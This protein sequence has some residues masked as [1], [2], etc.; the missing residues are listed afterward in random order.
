MLL[1]PPPPELQREL[2]SENALGQQLVMRGRLP[3]AFDVFRHSYEQML[4]AQPQGQRYHKGLPL[5]NMGWA[6]LR[7][8]LPDQG[9]RWTVMA[10]IEDALSRAE[11]MPN[12]L[13]ELSRPA[14][15]N[16]RLLG[17]PEPEL[18]E[19]ARLV[20]AQITIADASVADPNALFV[21]LGLQDRLMRWLGFSRVTPVVRVFVSSPRELRRERVLIA[22]ICR[23]LSLV[24]AAH[25]EALLWEGAGVTN[26]EV[27]PFPPEITGLGGQAVIDDHIWS[28]L[29]G[30][31]IYVGLLWRRMGTP[32]STWRSG[33]EAE[34]RFAFA[35][36]LA[37]GRPRHILFYL[38]GLRPGV[39]RDADAA[40]FASELR[41][42]G[43]VTPFA[44]TED[45]RRAAFS[46][47]ATL[48][49]EILAQ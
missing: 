5:H 44:S 32:T 41:T 18:V 8:G 9:A 7:A 37:S 43:L 28:R 19:I 3:E 11:E 42:L 22:E 31:D 17:A 1:Q 29:G 15:Q 27:Q 25:V 39:S 10:F 46:H 23:E 14:A 20:R 45:L 48:V 2:E 40:D 26:P 33:T 13:D 16:L 49:R 35:H 38:K 47:L 34:F 30:Y 21:G 4:S 36:R 12:V 6:R 24:L